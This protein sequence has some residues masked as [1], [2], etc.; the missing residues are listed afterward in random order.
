MATKTNIDTILQK[1][2]QNEKNC[3]VKCFYNSTM[4]DKRR[5][6]KQT[7]TDIMKEWS[8]DTMMAKTDGTVIGG[9]RA[10]HL[11]E[12]NHTHTD[13]VNQFSVISVPPSIIAVTFQSFNRTYTS[14]TNPDNFLM[15]DSDITTCIVTP[16]EP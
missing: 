11:D 4:A 1:C 3:M 2:K 13:R 7:F 15:K 16:K 9:T 8:P 6:C 5:P 14:Q 10:I 12:K